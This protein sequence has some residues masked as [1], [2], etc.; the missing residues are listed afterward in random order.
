[1]P[2]CTATLVL[3]LYRTTTYETY[4]NSRVA[5][6]KNPQNRWRTGVLLDPAMCRSWMALNL[7][8]FLVPVPEI[9]DPVF[10]K[11]SSK[12]SFLKT[13][14]ERFGLVFTKT[15]VYKFGHRC[16][17]A[18]FCGVISQILW[19]LLTGISFI[20]IQHINMFPALRN[21][22]IGWIFYSNN[23]DTASFVKHKTSSHGLIPVPYMTWP[24]INTLT[25]FLALK[26]QWNTHTNLSFCLF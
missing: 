25:F 21:V 12:R 18:D 10:K 20:T 22:T 1:M 24:S 17:Y 6:E 11:T 14:Y 2:R 23:E 16:F 9:I 4:V 8:N 7:L 19:N 5:A 26:K 13:E 15:R 3:Q